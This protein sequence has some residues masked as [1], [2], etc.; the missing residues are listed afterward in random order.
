MFGMAALEAQACGKPVICSNQ[1]GLPEVVSPKSGLFFPVGD[2]E[3]LADSLRKL[4]LDENLYN[5]KA[6]ASRLNALA[7]PG[8]ES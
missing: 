8:R 4:L 3:K 1:G 6:E 2:A 5:S 7:F